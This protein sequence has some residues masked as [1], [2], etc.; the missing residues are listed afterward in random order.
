[1]SVDVSPAGAPICDREQ[2]LDPYGRDGETSRPRRSAFS[3]WSA[4]STESISSIPNTPHAIATA[5]GEAGRPGEAQ[6]N[7]NA[8]PNIRTE[9]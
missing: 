4:K 7:M 9:W 5:A 6:G 8:Y 3:S 2:T 1:M